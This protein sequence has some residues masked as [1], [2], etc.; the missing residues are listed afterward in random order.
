MYMRRECQ[1]TFMCL[2]RPRVDVFRTYGLGGQ[3]EP[4]GY[5]IQPF[6][7]MDRNLDIYTTQNQLLYTITGNC[8]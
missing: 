1:C 8:C 3:K 6:K 7:C 2:N 4:L 5:I